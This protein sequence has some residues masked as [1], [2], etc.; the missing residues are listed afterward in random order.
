MST[1]QEIE[2]MFKDIEARE[3]KLSPWAR[4]F[5]DSVQKYW[6]DKGGLSLKQDAKL[7]EIW[8]EVTNERK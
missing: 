8:D 5:V 2:Q 1:K 3:D 6:T 4:S 7:T